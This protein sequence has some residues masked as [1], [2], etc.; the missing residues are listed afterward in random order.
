MTLGPAQRARYARHLLLPEL[1]EAGQ[2][3]LLAARVRPTEGADGEAW[4]VARDYLAR[5]GVE[6]DAAQGTPVALLDASQLAA[7]AGEP[8]LTEA[9]KV[10]AGALCAVEA[11][12]RFAGLGV[13][14]ALPVTFSLSSEDA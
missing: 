2:L 12:K 11:I 10:L 4:E 1:G 3:K 6:E 14:A 8:R 13:P 7:L 5:A 9:A